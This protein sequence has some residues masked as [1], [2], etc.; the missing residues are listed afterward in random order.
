MGISREALSPGL[1]CIEGSLLNRI[2]FMLCCFTVDGWLGSAIWM[3]IEGKNGSTHGKKEERKK[4][5]SCT[6]DLRYKVHKCN[7]DMGGLDQI[8]P[9]FIME[10]LQWIG[11]S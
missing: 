8:S 5:N 3:I 7:L 11:S 6:I 10:L 9:V 1:F 4:R 2:V